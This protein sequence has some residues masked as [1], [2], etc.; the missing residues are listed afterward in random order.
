MRISSEFYTLLGIFVIVGLGYSPISHSETSGTLTLTSGFDYSS[1]DY[2][3]EVDTDISAIP[4][5]ARYELDRWTFKATVPYIHIKGPGDVIPSIGQVTQTPRRNRTS[6]SGWGDT[7]VSATYSFYPPIAQ[8]LVID[9][10]GKVKFDTADE[11]KGLGTGEN[12][13]SAQVDIYKVFGRFTAIAG[14]GYRVYGN[15]DFG[16]LDNVFYGSVG[17]AYKLSDTTSIGAIYDYRPKIIDTGSEISEVLSFVSHKLTDQWKLQ[18]YFVKGF[19]NG[20]PDYGG[21]AML[22]H[23]F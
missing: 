23:S 10:T 2:G 13:Y 12:D 6:E 3:D 5:V 4:F 19:S 11:D 22:S 1:G 21:G 9:L 18:G 7:V 20:S 16:T 15:P 17:G 14:V 8:G